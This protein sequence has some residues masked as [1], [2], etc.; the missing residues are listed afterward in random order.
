[1][2]ESLPVGVP[3]ARSE[4]SSSRE[5]PNARRR[6]PADAKARTQARIVEAAASLFAARGYE[7]ASITSIAA[8]AQVSRSAVFW[9]FGDKETLFRETFRQM[10]LPFAEKI[11]NSFTHPDPAVR[12][13]ELL[14]VY[15]RFVDEQ[16]SA[17]QAFVRWTI[18]SPALRHS[19]REPL[20]AMH[21]HFARDVS[22]A[23]AQALGDAASAEAMA[24]GILSMLHG[25]LL[26]AMVDGDPRRARLRCAGLRSVVERVLASGPGSGP[27]PAARSSRGDP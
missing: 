18:E 14:G 19:I 10:L 9:H 16:K 17:I 5:P 20:F 15:E 6:R 22:E 23:L 3:V 1:M 24:M 27:G 11:A 8:R 26:L 12:L 21:D 25:N 2:P 13:L 4:P 7:G